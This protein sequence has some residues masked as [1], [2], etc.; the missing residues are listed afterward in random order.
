MSI[1][2]DDNFNNKPDEEPENPEESEKDKNDGNMQANDPVGQ[3]PKRRKIKV[4]T[5]ENGKD[6]KF[7]DMFGFTVTPSH[8]IVKFGVMQPESGEFVIHSQIA[9]TPQGLIALHQALGKN[10]EKIRNI[11]PG[12]GQILN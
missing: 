4:V 1:P 6:V 8:A 7:S 11:K 3:N 5:S 9:M 12:K 2:P 10:I